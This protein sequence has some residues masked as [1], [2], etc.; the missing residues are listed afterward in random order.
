MDY[1]SSHFTRICWYGFDMGNSAHALLVSTV[2]F[3]L[4]YKQFL[5]RGSAHADSTWGLLT[6]F[7]L[8]VSAISSPFL[9]SWASHRS[10]RGTILI[11]TTVTSIG[12]TALL[13]LDVAT[14]LAPALVLYIISALGFYLA[15]PVYNSL[16]PDIAQNREER[17]SAAGW[18]LGYVGGILAVAVGLAL[19]ILEADVASQPEVFRRIFFVAAALNLLFSLGMLILAGRGDRAPI[20]ETEP[21]GL[22]RAWTVFR[23]TPSLS[24]LL[25][26]Y[27]LV[28]EAGT[29]VVYFT[30]LLLAGVG[31]MAAGDIL[32]LTLLVQGIAILT[33]FSAGWVAHWLG[34]AR[35]FVAVAVGW[36]AA[37][38]ALFGYSLVGGQTYWF[39]LVIIGLVLGGHHTLVRSEVARRAKVMRQ[40]DRFTLAD[41]GALF[42]FLEVAGRISQVLGPLVVGVA[43]LFLE[44]GGAVAVTAI[45]PLVALVVIRKY[46]WT[47]Y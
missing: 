5:V 11:A 1:R 47:A 4:Y 44:L 2:G 17:T 24:R 21:W 40:S 30:A 9:T 10:R 29:V 23:A 45:F 39:A 43:T 15:L 16:L 38:L 26:A 7:V 36:V 33:T 14:Q 12:A 8:A 13:G 6:A 19:G 35:V 28:S 34:P 37:P 25:I 46:V 18:A 22:S 20:M 27:W 42:G 32:V 3:S 31:G 41:E